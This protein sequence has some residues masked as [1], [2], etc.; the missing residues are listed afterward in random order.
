MSP[1]DDRDTPS[2]S[3]LDTPLDPPLDPRIHPYRDDLAA[4]FLEGRVE[5]RSFVR[6]RECRA[7]SAFVPVMTKPDVGALQSTELLFGEPFTVY[8][9]TGG[10]SWGQCGHDGYVGYAPANAIFNNLPE[11][12]HWVTASRSLVFPDAKG[13]YPPSMGLSLGALVGVE[14]REGDYA[15]LATGGWMFGSHLAALGETRPD[16]IAT[17]SMFSRVPYLWGGR[18]GQGIDCSGLIQVALAAAGTPAPRDSDQ[19]ADAIG[20]DVPIPGDPADLEAGD[21]VF[22]PGHVG[23]YLGAGA[24]LHATS[25]DMMVATHSLVDVLQRVMERHGKGITRVRRLETE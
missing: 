1:A 10:W 18:G 3:P 9:K 22:F 21:I 2:D 23:F 8:E 5:S 4:D 16:F 11:P 14:A 25:H 12:T 17:A 7:G 24:L 15:K 13:E 19:Q 6:G 20:L